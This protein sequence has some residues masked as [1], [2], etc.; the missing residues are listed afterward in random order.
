MKAKEKQSPII[1]RNESFLSPPFPLNFSPGERQD[2]V[3]HQYDG[4][5]AWRIS[6]TISTGEAYFQYWG[7]C[8][9]QNYQGSLGG[10][11]FCIL[12]SVDN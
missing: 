11:G 7:G 5:C 10:V 1:S 9:L 8:S 2:N 12:P 4:G 6:H 3:H